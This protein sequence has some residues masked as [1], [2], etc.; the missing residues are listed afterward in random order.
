MYAVFSANTG[1]VATGKDLKP[2]A[3]EVART[4]QAFGQADDITVLT[5]GRLAVKTEDETGEVAAAG[6]ISKA[7]RGFQRKITTGKP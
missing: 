1:L 2:A 7:R 4:A 3:E 5:V 6:A